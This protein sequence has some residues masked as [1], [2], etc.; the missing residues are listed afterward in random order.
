MLNIAKPDPPTYCPQHTFIKVSILFFS[1][2]H[3][4]HFFV[5][6]PDSQVL[7][8][9]PQAGTDDGDGY[10]Q[11]L[12]SSP[13]NQRYAASQHRAS[14]LAVGFYYSFLPYYLHCFSTKSYSQS[15]SIAEQMFLLGC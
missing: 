2:P 5:G 9:S 1:F 4:E 14:I 11:T 7:L 6:S 15:S 8:G 10:P 12:A 13:G 3:T